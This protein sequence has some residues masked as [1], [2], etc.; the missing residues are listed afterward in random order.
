MPTELLPLLVVVHVALAVT[1]FLPTILLPFAFRTRRSAAAPGQPQPAGP[2]TRALLWL[3]A[4]GTTYVGAGV[5]L[6]GIGLIAVLGTSLISQPWLLVALAIYALNLVVAF[7][8]QRPTLRRVLRMTPSRDDRDWVLLAR[9][10]RYVSYAMAA[11]IGTIGFL[12]S[13][14]P[15]L[16]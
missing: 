3:Q 7:F 4:N 5:A 2:V 16:W 15:V 11:L 10:Q 1:L 6:T 8:I 12:M 9:R 13:Q 14:K